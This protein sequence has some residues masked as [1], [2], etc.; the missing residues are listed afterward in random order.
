MKLSVIIPVYRVETTLDRCVSSVIGQNI[1]DMEVILVDDGSPDRCPEL[2]DEWVQKDDRIRVIHKVNGGLSDARNAALDIAKGDYV[3]FVDSD[4]WLADNTYALLLENIGDSD[5]MEYSISERLMLTDRTYTDIN[6]YWLTEKAY[7]HTYACN[8]IYRRNLF[9]NIRFPKGRIFED[10]Y[11]FPKL[12]QQTSVIRTSHLGAYHYS[13]NPSSITATADGTGLAQ[14]LDAHLTNGMPVD[15][16]YYLHLVNIQMDVW[17]RTGA[18]IL[19]PERQVDT[20]LFK[21]HN[22]L[23]AVLLNKLGIRL[24][25][26]IN[27]LIHYVRKPNR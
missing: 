3:T 20:S 5:I 26:R 14:L 10:A 19:L 9:D 12:L 13:W 1:S 18:P 23:K 8:K 7:T 4:D 25:C 24:L 22:K 2:C 11:T 17:E 16:C 27:K 21:G 6:D 15:D